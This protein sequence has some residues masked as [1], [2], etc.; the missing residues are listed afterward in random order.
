MT[1]ADLVAKKLAFIETRLR[2]LRELAQPE[3]IEQDLRE[4]RFVAH[5]LQIAIQSALDVASHIVSDERL[6]EPENNR[7]LFELLVEN[8]WAPDELAE[9]LARM[10]AFRNVLVRGYQAVDKVVI[11]DVVENYLDDL[12]AYV[13][14]IRSRMA[15][16]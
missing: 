8:R 7:Q 13:T 9:P 10:V 14:A 15:N 4:E 12:N 5:T 16:P 1:D 3:L 2:E 6:G 11:R